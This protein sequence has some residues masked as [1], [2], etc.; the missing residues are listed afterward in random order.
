MAGDGAKRG[1]GKPGT[2]EA[3]SG[4]ATPYPV[5]GESRP[6][7][8]LADSPSS[9]VLGSEVV[10]G[11]GSVGIPAPPRPSSYMPWSELVCCS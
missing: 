2:P 8:P 3:F 11:A 10:L 4:E 5:I 7:R 1:G 9:Y 6:V